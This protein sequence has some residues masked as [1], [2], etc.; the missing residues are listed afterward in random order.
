MRKTLGAV[1]VATALMAGGGHLWAEWRANVQLQQSWTPVG[2]RFV[3]VSDDDRAMA[4]TLEINGIPA[5]TVGDA[6][7]TQTGLAFFKWDDNKNRYASFSLRNGGFGTSASFKYKPDGGA[8]G[9]NGYSMWADWKQLEVK[10]ATNGNMGWGAYVG[11]GSGWNHS[12]TSLYMWE[13]QR[14]G[15]AD[16]YDED[17]RPYL[18][19]NTGNAGSP[20]NN[21]GD[22]GQTIGLQWTQGGIRGTDTLNLRLVSVY[23]SGYAR[24]ANWDSIL[25]KGW[26]MQVNY[27]MPAWVFTTTF[28]FQGADANEKDRIARTGSFAWHVAASTSVINNLSVQLG[29]TLGG[30]ALNSFTTEDG[31]E[32]SNTFYGHD[33][34]L[35]LGWR[36]GDWNMNFSTRTT[37][38]MLSEYSKVLSD[39]EAYGWRPYLGESVSLGASKRMNGLM[40]GNIAV[41]FDDYNMNSRTGGKAEASVW[42]GPSVDISPARGN[43]IHIGLSVSYDNFSDE[44]KGWFCPE[45]VRRICYTYPGTWSIS[46]PMT[47]YILF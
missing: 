47:F 1:A 12:V 18:T 46:I 11:A 28:K 8:W 41:G 20:L 35:I 36:M 4:H 9:F 2:A 25:P 22:G 7:E 43:T 15:A 3:D 33:V 19:Y 29:Y 13:V 34:Q 37:L 45:G 17:D 40:T 32:L 23:S 10:Y 42:F 38:I 24:Y 30:Q 26:N 27:R 5:G 21:Q 39:K 44:A 16:G 6:T 31:K 14:K